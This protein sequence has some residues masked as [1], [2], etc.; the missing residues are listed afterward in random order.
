MIPVPVA[1]LSHWWTMAVKKNKNEKGQAIFELI[2]FLPIFLF[3][4]KSLFD[5]GDAINLGINQLKVVRG[6]YFYSVSHDTMVPNAKFLEDFKNNGVNHV[7]L[8]AFSWSLDT[9]AESGGSPVGACVK[10][11][12]FLGNEIEEECREANPVDRKTQF[13]RIYSSFGVCTGTWSKA[14]A[15]S[16]NP[17]VLN[18][19]ESVSRQ[20]AR[21]E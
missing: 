21:T 10:V 20:C 3:L 1:K 19:P 2:I 16:A 14:E 13:I 12:G 7:S 6:Y 8:D 5:Y 15:A 17:Y 18:W 4:I 11:Y 9:I